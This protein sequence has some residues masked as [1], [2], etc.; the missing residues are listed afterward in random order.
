VRPGFEVAV[1]HFLET[2][3]IWGG[4]GDPPE[5]HSPLYVSIIDEIKER[6]GA[7]KGEV[8]VGEPWEARV[9]TELIIVK[10]TADLPKWKRTA[11]DEW[12]WV[13]DTT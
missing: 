13:P 10:A 1:T 4:E 12:Q 8:P 9:P 3:K 7:P 5:I 6:T 11:P 2:G